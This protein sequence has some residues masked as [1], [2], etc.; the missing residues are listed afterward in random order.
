MRNFVLIA[1]CLFVLG[2]GCK[3]TKLKTE[4]Q[5]TTVSSEKLEKTSQTVV[6]EVKK[7]EIKTIDKSTT[8]EVTIWEA[9]T[10]VFSAPDSIGKQHLLS[11]TNTK[12]KS[13]KGEQKNVEA[14][15]KDSSNVSKKTHITDKLNI[16]VKAKNKIKGDKEEEIKSPVWVSVGVVI[17]I[18]GLVFLL[19]LFL[20][21]VD[22]ITKIIALWKKIIKLLP[23]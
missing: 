2:V 9:N 20:K 11:E 4:L 16:N 8:Q 7:T 23:W 1:I 12:G 21:K 19:F 18:T 5:N 15:K 13:V 14:S 22:F 3:T 10:K 17:G 6:D